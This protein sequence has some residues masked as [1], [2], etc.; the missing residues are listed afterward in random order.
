GRVVDLDA[1]AR[2]ILDSLKRRDS[3]R[4]CAAVPIPVDGVGQWPDHGDRIDG[5]LLERQEGL[6]I[7]EKDDRFE[8]HLLRDCPN[9]VGVPGLRRILDG[10]VWDHL[11]RVDLRLGDGTILHG[12]PGFVQIL[13]EELIYACFETRDYGS[14]LIWKEM[15]RIDEELDCSSI[16]RNHIDSPFLADNDLESKYPPAEPEALRCEPL[17]AA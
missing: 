16:A 14:F 12:C 6:F 17:K 4:R 13:V 1:W 11:R 2:F 15:T 5:F 10:R 8:C 3:V 7:L 9:L